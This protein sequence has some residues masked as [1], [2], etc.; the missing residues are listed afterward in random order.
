MTLAQFFELRY[1][2][3]F[4]VFTG[5]LGFFAGILNFGIIPV[6]GARFITTFIGLPPVVEVLGMDVGTH[7]IV[8]AVLLSVTLFLTLV[9]GQ[10]TVMVTDCLEGILSQIL[11]LGYHR[12]PASDV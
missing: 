8:M 10:I 4:R 7:L 1:S 9:G 3:R 2:K 5:F 6:I 12:E 11:Y